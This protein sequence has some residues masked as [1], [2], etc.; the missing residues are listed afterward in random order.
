M[1]LAEQVQAAA[2][3]NG[4]TAYLGLNRRSYSASL[5]ARAHLETDPGPR[6]IH[7]LDQQSFGEARAAGHPE[8]VVRNFM[9]ANSIH[10]IDYLVQFGR[11]DVVSVTPD[12]P[13]R[14]EKTFAHGAT[15]RFAS[16]DIGRYDALW[17]A[18]GPWACTIAT[19]AVRFEM[20]P[21]EALSSQAAGTRRL[22]PIAIDPVDQIYKAGFFRQA[23]EMLKAV[24]GEPNTMPTLAHGLATMRLIREIYV[25]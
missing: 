24:R 7:V 2:E 21:L 3:A 22:E 23:Q 5:Q 17:N 11:G 15:I 25:S 12:A 18:P 6:F 10:L 13:W 16:G 14:G 9:Y 19:P 1:A 8:E 4:K 20:R